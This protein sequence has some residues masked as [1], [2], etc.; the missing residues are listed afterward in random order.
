MAADGLGAEQTATNSGALPASVVG[1]CGK[2]PVLPGGAF[3]FA[4]LMP[5][6]ARSI[7]E[8]FSEP[9]RRQGCIARGVLNVA[10]PEIGLYRPG[11]VTVVGKLIAAGV[12]Q[13]MSVRKRI[14][15][16]HA[17]RQTQRR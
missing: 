17:L 12:A 6:G 13:H 16:H 5:A 10:M 8:K 2:S 15:V 4:R 7:S 3:P 14:V 11:V 1:R 9:L